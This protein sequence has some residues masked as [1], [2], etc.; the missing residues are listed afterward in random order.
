MRAAAAALALLAG[1]GKSEKPDYVPGGLYSVSDGKAFKVAKVLAA[2]AAA[3]HIRLYKNSWPQRPTSVDPA[4]LQLGSIQDKDGFGVGHLPLARDS[5]ANWDP[6]F[7]AATTLT[8]DD[9]QGYE[10]WKKNQ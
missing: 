3:V 9:L 4:T 8:S 1:C 7:L 5:F 6:V 2:D 10:V